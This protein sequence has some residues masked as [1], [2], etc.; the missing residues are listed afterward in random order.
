[1]IHINIM[2]AVII[3]HS[4]NIIVVVIIIEDIVILVDNVFTVAP[5]NRVTAITTNGSRSSNC[6]ISSCRR[7]GGT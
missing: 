1:M 6:R 7:R 2:F 4:S 3:I 5:R